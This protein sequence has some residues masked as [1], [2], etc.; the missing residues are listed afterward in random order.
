MPGSR[1]SHRSP[2]TTGAK[3]TAAPTDPAVRRRLAQSLLN[4]RGMADLVFIATTI[5]VFAVAWAYLR[6]CD[7]L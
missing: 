4:D 2:C 1:E 7:R 5:A 6:G 3:A